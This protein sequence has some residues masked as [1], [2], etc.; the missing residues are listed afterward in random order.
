MSDVATNTSVPRLRLCEPSDDERLADIVE[1]AA[2]SYDIV[3]RSKSQRTPTL[4][5]LQLAVRRQLRWWRTAYAAASV[6]LDEPVF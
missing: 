3:G 4:A 5:R 2:E 1:A 6:R